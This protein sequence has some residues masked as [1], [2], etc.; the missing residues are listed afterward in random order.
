MGSRQTIPAALSSTFVNSDAIRDLARALAGLALLAALT[1]CQALPYQSRSDSIATLEARLD[2]LERR[3]LT[4]QVLIISGE[5]TVLARAMGRLHPEA[6]ARVRMDSVMPL[7]SV[8]KP[9]TA[10]ALLALAADGRVDLDDPVGKHVAGLSEDLQALP[11]HHLLTHTAGLTAEIFNPAWTGHPR[12]EPI[13]RDELV[14]RVNQFPPVHPPGEV[15]NYSNVG[16]TL[17]AA[18][19]ESVSGL[20]LEQFLRDRLLQPA[21]IADIGLL[22]PDWDAR[23]VV[24]GRD[25]SQVSGHHLLEPRLDDGMGWHSRGSSDLLA[26]PDAM[27]A[28]WQSL[29]AR[30]WLPEPVMGAF[31]TPQVEQSDGARYG[32][33]LEFRQGPLG[34]E[35]AHAGSD[36]DFTI[37]WTWFAQHDTM[38]YVALAD[39]R[40]RADRITEMLAQ[41]LVSEFRPERQDVHGSFSDEFSYIPKTTPP[42]HQYAR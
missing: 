12:F 14:R 16:Y 20:S 36:L 33:G 34:K 39:S 19:V 6:P 10:S 11:L 32:Y 24:S 23:D 41:S 38:I 40:W 1:A 5:R 15:F 22:L 31:L 4:G 9:F 30:T 3:G 42:A 13:G 27:A 8:S 18:V 37:T 17:L 2:R 25:G 21:G 28:W 29:R 35:I 7:A 26:R